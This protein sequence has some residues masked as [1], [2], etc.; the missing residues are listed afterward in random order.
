MRGGVGAQAKVHAALCDNFDTSGALLSL[1]DLVTEVNKY[2]GVPEPRHLLVRKAALYTT[3]I[4]KVF[5]LVE[6]VDDIG[7]P[8]GGAG[9]CVSEVRYMWCTCECCDGLQAP[10]CLC[11]MDRRF[12]ASVDL[13]CPT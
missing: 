2:L 7:F 12:R 8:T 6:T 9:G 11:S 3:Q 1:C 13:S 10:C 4:L 5:G